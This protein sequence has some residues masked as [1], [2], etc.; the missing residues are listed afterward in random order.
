MSEVS[1]Q[2]AS[3]VIA[4]LEARKG[5]RFAR[6]VVV[7]YNI[8]KLTIG[9]SAHVF[10]QILEPMN[11]VLFEMIDLAGFHE[12]LYAVLEAIDTLAKA[13]AADKQETRK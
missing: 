2:R 9:H 12:D 11:E 4:A 6:L 1:A 5:E 8:R 13:I 10:A 7:L 3:E